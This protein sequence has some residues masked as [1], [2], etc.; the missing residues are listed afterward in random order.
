MSPARVFE[1]PAPDNRDPQTLVSALDALLV[2]AHQLSLREQDLRRKVLF[3]H[4]Q[5]CFWYFFFLFPRSP[6]DERNVIN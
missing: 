1:T 3:A 5:V 6:Y 2:T 4:D